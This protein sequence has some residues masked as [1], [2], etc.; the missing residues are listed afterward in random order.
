MLQDR[1]PTFSLNL[2]GIGGNGGVSKVGDLEWAN[3]SGVQGD[4][5][6]DDSSIESTEGSS[7]VDGDLEKGAE[8]TIKNDDP[9]RTSTT[10][11]VT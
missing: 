10:C 4:S 11:V 2:S 3:P 8:L 7:T 6:G 1:V 5:T 9:R